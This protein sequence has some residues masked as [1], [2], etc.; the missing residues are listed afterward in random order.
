[1]SWWNIITILNAQGEGSPLV[2]LA[3]IIGIIVGFIIVNVFKIGGGF[4]KY[5][6][7]KR[8]F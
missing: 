8:R 7:R 6:Y 4:P 3:I 1:M 2:A 5:E